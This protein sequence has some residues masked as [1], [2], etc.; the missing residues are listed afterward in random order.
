MLEL[1]LLFSVTFVCAFLIEVVLLQAFLRWRA[2]KQKPL[3]ANT[4]NADFVMLEDIMLIHTDEV[5]DE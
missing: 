3:R 5:I 1:L 4:D 2:Q